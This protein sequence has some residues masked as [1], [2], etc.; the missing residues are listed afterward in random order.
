MFDL[1][2]TNPYEN[3]YFNRP[4]HASHASLL[5]QALRQFN[6]ARWESL[7]EKVKSALFRRAHALLDLESIPQHQVR[8]RRYGGIKPVRLERIC[9]SLGRTGDFD[10]HFYPREDRLRDRWVSIAIARSQNIPLEP[11]ALIQVGDCYFVQDG[12]HRIS[13]ARARG[14][15]AIDAEI[16]LWEV[17]CKLPWEKQTSP[18]ILPQ[19]A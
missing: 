12:H 14:E 10:H 6:Q 15:A 16:T 5:N 8:T 7:L 11:V 2:S 9:G 18:G 17:G 1:R 3:R 4:A 19:T 13:V